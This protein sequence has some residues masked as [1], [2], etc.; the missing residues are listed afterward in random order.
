MEFILY[1]MDL[2]NDSNLKNSV[3]GQDVKLHPGVPLGK[4][5]TSIA[6]L[7]GWRRSHGSTG[8]GW[9]RGQVE[10]NSADGFFTDARQMIFSKTM[11]GITGLVKA[12]AAEESKENYFK[13][14]S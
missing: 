8:D 10:H 12:T 7:P 14:S 4:D 13:T 6:S 5:S 2:F 11:A 1:Q 9:R 3:L